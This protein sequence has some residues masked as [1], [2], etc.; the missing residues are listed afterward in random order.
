M[1]IVSRDYLLM[2]EISR[3][4]FLLGRQ[5][6]ILAGF[7]SQRT[8]D[9]R[10]KVLKESGYIKGV[11]KLYGIPALYFATN[12]AKTVFNLDFVTT[13]VK[14]ARIL[15]DIAV[16]DTAIY[17]MKKL[18]ACDIKSE[19]EFRHNKGFKREGHYPDFICKISGVTYAVEVELTLK[20]KAVFENNIK[21]NFLEYDNQV[22]VV[23]KDKVKIWTILEDNENIYSNLSLIPME[24]VTGY[25]KA[26]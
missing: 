9:R 25:V 17:F 20:N 12:K 15:H 21:N 14:V 13:D 3:W 11:Y 7:P 8:V 19:R 6:R 22:W 23:P 10:I 2:Q 26:L 16:V 4:R 5:I 1:K 24:E 18:G